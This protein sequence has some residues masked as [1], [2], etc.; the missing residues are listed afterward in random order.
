MTDRIRGMIRGG[1]ARMV[2]RTGNPGPFEEAP[3]PQSAPATVDPSTSQTSAQAGSPSDDVY[4][5][6]SILDVIVTK[7]LLHRGCKLP[8]ELVEVILE[9]AEYWPHTTVSVDYTTGTDEPFRVYASRNENEFLVS[10]PAA[11]CL[12]RIKFDVLTIFL[13]ADPHPPYRLPYFPPFRHSPAPPHETRPAQSLHRT[14]SRTPPVLRRLA[15]SDCHQPMPQD[16]LHHRQQRPGLGW[17]LGVP[18]HLPTLLLVVRRWLG[19]VR[20]Q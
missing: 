13:L 5:G 3:N 10:L 9:Q 6:L 18:R 17:R 2:P 14:P 4:Q 11:P 15:R 19:E 1:P 12:H 16:R 7:A 8:I 20:S